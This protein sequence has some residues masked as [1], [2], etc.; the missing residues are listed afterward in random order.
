MKKNKLNNKSVS[1][2]TNKLFSPLYKN[3]STIKNPLS[4]KLPSFLYLNEILDLKQNKNDN[5]RYY[6]KNPQFLNSSNIQNQI[7][8][9]STNINN[10]KNNKYSN[11]LVKND[12]SNSFKILPKL[13]SLNNLETKFGIKNVKNEETSFDS[14]LNNKN[15]SS[16]KLPNIS[17][18][19]TNLNKKKLNINNFE[20]SEQ[21]RKEVEYDY[22]SIFSSSNLFKEKVRYID[23]KLNIVYC[24]NESQYKFIMEKRNK[25]LK[26]GSV[27]K[28][29]EDSEKVKGQVK[30]IKEKIKFMKNVMDFSYPGFMLTKIKS[31]EKNLSNQKHDTLPT[32]YENQ[33][34]QIKKRN[35]LRTD[36]LKQN[37]KIFPLKI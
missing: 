13:K 27:L 29:E 14:T 23:N 31:W 34:N 1:T 19:T 36:Y 3:K 15:D 22:R 10:N 11:T 7:D 9:L 25:L 18:S 32:P 20:D 4:I 28:F 26:N 33:K 12:S 17:I 16:L 2:S 5:N 21:K 24:Q 8:I 30:D 6:Y 35:N 37:L